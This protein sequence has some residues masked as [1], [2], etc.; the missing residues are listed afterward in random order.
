[1]TKVEYQTQINA[2]VQKVYEY[3]TDPN[4]IQEAWP[5]DIIKESKDVSGSKNEE[6]SEMRV[7]GQYM[8]KEEEMRLQIVDKE[9]NRR[10]VTQQVQGPFK[11]WESIQEFQA[12]DGRTTHIRHTIDY[13]LPTT[14]K[15]ANMLSGSQADNK[16]REGLHQAAQSVK[17]KL[18]S[19]KAGI[20]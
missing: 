11:K 15:I 10:L 17:Q 6:G 1:M 8:G 9:Q 5:R 16:M 12:S 20:E 4:N 14:G 7:K 2:P 18:E 13:E 19:S 3:Y